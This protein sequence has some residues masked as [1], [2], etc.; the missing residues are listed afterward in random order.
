MFGGSP[1][2]R[3][4]W[5]EFPVLLHEISMMKIE[6][7]RKEREKRMKINEK[8]KLTKIAWFQIPD[9]EF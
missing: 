2:V 3:S 5:M 6:D 8:K 9:I 1:E 7:E 4:T